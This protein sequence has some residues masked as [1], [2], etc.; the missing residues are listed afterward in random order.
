MSS[1]KASNR[2]SF[3]LPVLSG[4]YFRKT[5]FVKSIFPFT[6]I[7]QAC[8]QPP[9]AQSK[10]LQISQKCQKAYKKRADISKHSLKYHTQVKKYQT[11][12]HCSSFPLSAVRFLFTSLRSRLSESAPSSF[13][14]RHPLAVTAVGEVRDKAV[15]TIARI[16]LSQ[17]IYGGYSAGELLKSELQDRRVTTHQG[18]TVTF[19][20]KKIKDRQVRQAR[21]ERD[22]SSTDRRRSLLKSREGRTVD[23]GPVRR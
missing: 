20:K 7:C 2:L 13:D 4:S 18:V 6:T 1:L 11:S 12:L 5:T 17:R 22:D 16:R 21:A 10:K 14:L 3:S 15:P 19:I 23:T 8:H 9:K